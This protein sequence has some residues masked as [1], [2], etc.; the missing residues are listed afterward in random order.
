MASNLFSHNGLKY[1]FRH[2]M[3][4]TKTPINIDISMLVD[5]ISTLGLIK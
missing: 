5:I 1:I 2:E 3:V 4:D